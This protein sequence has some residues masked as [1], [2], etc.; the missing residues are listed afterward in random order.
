VTRGH[1]CIPNHTAL[2]LPLG[3]WPVLSFHAAEGRRLGTF[4]NGYPSQCWQSPS[5]L[6]L[7]QT[8]TM[9]CGCTLLHFYTS[10]CDTIRYETMCVCVFYASVCDESEPVEGLW[11]MFL[12]TDEVDADQA[13][14]SL[15]VV[16]LQ[17]KNS[18]LSLTYTNIPNVFRSILCVALE[19][20]YY[21]ITAT[22]FC[23]I[24]AIDL[25]AKE[26]KQNF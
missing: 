10:V 18:T 23:L 9:L 15:Q 24:M 1:G 22:S 11:P 19:I 2:Q 14:R 26:I 7:S 13:R 21:S 25:F 6:Q 3:A 20:V 17:G 8:S 16:G 4:V 12:Y 5:P